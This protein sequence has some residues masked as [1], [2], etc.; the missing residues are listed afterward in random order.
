MEHPMH[1]LRDRLQAARRTAL[2]RLAATAPE[3]DLWSEGLRSVGALQLAFLA[4][5]DEL[6][7][8]EPK[9]GYG[10]EQPLA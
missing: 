3:T 4:I 6:A 7:V 1:D 8:H 10:G 5:Q 2:E 9:V